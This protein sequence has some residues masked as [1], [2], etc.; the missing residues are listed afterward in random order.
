MTKHFIFDNDHSKTS[1]K[2]KKKLFKEIQ[3]H[4]AYLCINIVPEL[5]L[6]QKSVGSAFVLL[7]N[8]E[9]Y[10]GSLWQHCTDVVTISDSIFAE[11]KRHLPSSFEF[12]PTRYQHIST[13]KAFQKHKQKLYFN[14]CDDITPNTW[15]PNS[16]DLQPPPHDYVWGAQFKKDKIPLFHK[17]PQISSIQCGSNRTKLNW[18]K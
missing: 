4:L 11:C 3:N 2:K 15:L 6:Q 10:S 12:S 9:Q 14:F 5:Q 16:P 13:M 8:P 17:G 7:T 18:F 1:I